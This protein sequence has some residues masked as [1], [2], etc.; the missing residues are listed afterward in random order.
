M[1]KSTLVIILI[2]SVFLLSAC[3]ENAVNEI[4]TDTSSKG[5]ATVIINPDKISV[6]DNQT[7]S[8]QNFDENNNITHI[9]TRIEYPG[10]TAYFVES[11]E[12]EQADESGIIT[13]N[14]PATE[15]ANIYVSA[16]NYNDI[17]ALFY[18]VKRGIYIEEDTVTEIKT[19]DID[20]VQADWK[21]GDKENEILVRDPF[22]QVD[23]RYDEY[24][25]GINGSSSITDDFTEDGYRKYEEAEGTPYLKH[26][27]FSLPYNSR[28]LINQS[29]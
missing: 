23:T 22:K 26:V 18:G 11:V 3:S 6:N 14:I 13:F 12:I 4:E 28:Y 8:S 20:W 10:E 19:E 25:I 17:K 1:K 16:V 29:E 7:L 5:L 24:F 15:N 2:L 27:F 21:Y 9:G